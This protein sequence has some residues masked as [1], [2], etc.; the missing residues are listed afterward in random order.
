MNVTYSVRVRVVLLLLYVSKHIVFLN[1]LKTERT[2]ANMNGK[3]FFYKC[4]LI[5]QSFI[6]VVSHLG[7]LSSGWSFLG[8]VFH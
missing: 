6:T 7:G 2:D 5:G 3:V 1:T 8:V 4:D